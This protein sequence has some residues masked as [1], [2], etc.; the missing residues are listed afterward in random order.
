MKVFDPGT[1]FDLPELPP[2]EDFFVPKIYAMLPDVRAALGELKGYSGLLPNPML[3]LSPAIVKESLASSE[4]ENIHTT[5]EEVLQQTLFP[6]AE[7]R[8][9][10]KEVLRYSDAVHWA[11]ASMKKIPIS[12][13]L[14]LGIQQRLMLGKNVGLRQNQNRII[15]QRKNETIYT[16]PSA[17]KIPAL[18][19]NLEKF[20]HAKD[21]LDPLVKTAIAHYQF[22]AIHPFP[23]GNG[24]TGRILMVLQLIHHD[25]LSY[26]ILYISGYVNANKSEYYKQL[27]NVSSSDSW[28]DFVQFMLTA[29]IDQALDTKRLLFDVLKLYDEL[30]EVLKTKHPLLSRSGILD[31]LFSSPI[32]TPVRLSEILGVHY[33]TA[34]RYLNELRDAGIL[35]D[36][37]VGKYHLYMHHKLLRI[38]TIV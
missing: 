21:L 10:N 16:P 32:V 31:T 24:R 20:I 33:S 12:T 28:I 13:R 11:F 17:E 23:D 22:E 15:D 25:I 34:T 27:R 1:P 8:P 7:Q 26:P 4:I 30:G 2:A 19:S 9:E 29:F 18:L 35:K 3:L 38:L 5:L 37:I 14:I 36:F 6:E